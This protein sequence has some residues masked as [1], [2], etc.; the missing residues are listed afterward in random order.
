L[1]LLTHQYLWVIP[2]TAFAALNRET[3]GLIPFMVGLYSVYAKVDASAQRSLLT[4]A[5]IAFGLYAIIYFGLRYAFGEQ[6]AI[7]GYGR[8]PGVEYL[9][10]N[11]TRLQTYTQIFATLGILPF[12]AI[13]S[14]RHWPESLRAF[15]WAI[16]P[17]WLLVHLF[18]GFVAETRYF[19]VPLAIVFVP[20]TLFGIKGAAKE[21]PLVLRHQDVTTG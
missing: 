6:S 16:V 20:G 13:Y 5:L 8:H 3:S 7:L 9:I 14:F 4:L 17:V 19:L 21:P 12:M 15:A 1:S 2:I 11:I 18:F 10:F